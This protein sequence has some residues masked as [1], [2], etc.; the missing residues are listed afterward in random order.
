ML[1][2]HAFLTYHL[3]Q[4]GTMEGLVCIQVMLCVVIYAQFCKPFFS[5]RSSPVISLAGIWLAV[6]IS[7]FHMEW[8][9]RAW[10]SLSCCNGPAWTG[11]RGEIGAWASWVRK[12]PWAHLICVLGWHLVSLGAVV[13]GHKNREKRSFQED[14]VFKKLRKTISCPTLVLTL[15]KEASLIA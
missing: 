11:S 14:E 15:G 12:K 3:S 9:E 1:V 8:T 4:R 10:G 6:C 5:V 7:F 13:P 2:A